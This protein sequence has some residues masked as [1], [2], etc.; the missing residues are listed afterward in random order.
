MTPFYRRH[1]WIFDVL[2]VVAFM[3]W[4]QQSSA[5]E[6]AQV[7]SGGG[8]AWPLVIVAVIALV[9]V[10]L[11]VWHKRNPAQSETVFHNIVAD[12]QAVASKAVDAAHGLQQTVAK[13]AAIIASPP[14]QAAINSQ[15]PA[16]PVTAAPPPEVPPMC[17]VEQRELVF[18]AIAFGETSPYAKKLNSPEYAPQLIGGSVGTTKNAYAGGTCCM[19]MPDGVDYW[20]AHTVPPGFGWH[21]KGA[22]V[23]YVNESGVPDPMGMTWDNKHQRFV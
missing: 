22:A 4:A 12:A 19:T 9:A 6:L 18:R 5:Q 1:Q 17:S 7:A 11:Y 20:H 21:Y 14:V 16:A 3:L 13:Q 2:T 8:G 23:G 15:P 10:G